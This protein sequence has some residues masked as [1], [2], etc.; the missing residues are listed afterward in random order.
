MICYAILCV[1]RGIQKS[2]PL[3]KN[4]TINLPCGLHST[5]RDVHLILAI[6][7]NKDV[8]VN[9]NNMLTLH[10]TNRQKMNYY[11]TEH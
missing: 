1:E 7:L 6:L 8:S 9:E 3:N 4:I 2:Q 5:V 10:L 11:K